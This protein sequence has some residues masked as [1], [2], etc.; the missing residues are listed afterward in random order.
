MGPRKFGLR[1]GRVLVP[2]GKASQLLADHLIIVKPLRRPEPAQE[3]WFKPNHLY[4]Y[5]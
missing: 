2:S 1:N 5:M 3:K 4:I